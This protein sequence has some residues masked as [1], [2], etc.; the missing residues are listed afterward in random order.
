MGRRG[1]MRTPKVYIYVL[2]NSVYVHKIRCKSTLPYELRS[3]R[4]ITGV[5]LPLESSG[6]CHI[7]QYRSPL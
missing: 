3:D 4:N 7:P 1:S 6:P 2:S 5:S